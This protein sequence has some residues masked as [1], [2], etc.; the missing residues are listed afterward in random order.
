MSRALFEAFNA[1][2][3]DTFAAF[4]ADGLEFYHDRDGLITKQQVLEAVRKNI[5]GKVRRELVSGSVEVYPIPN[6]GALETGVHRFYE[7]AQ[8]KPDKL[9]GIAKYAHVWRQTNDGWKLSR[10]LSYDHKP[11]QAP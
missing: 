5:C 9:V 6:H 1:C 3:L 7:V 11:A 8:G 2:D 4:T 10:V